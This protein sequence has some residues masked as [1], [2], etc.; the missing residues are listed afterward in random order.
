[1]NIIDDTSGLTVY[2]IANK[3]QVYP[4]NVTSL[5]LIESINGQ[6]S[7]DEILVELNCGNLDIVAKNVISISKTF[8]VQSE[9][10]VQIIADQNNQMAQVREFF[11]NKVNELSISDISSIKV[12][13][14]ALS[15]VT[16]TH[17]Q[18]STN[19]AVKIFFKE[20][21]SGSIF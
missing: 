11:V 17:Q 13:S 5:A 7:S 19:T 4:N 20:N 21:I 10:S 6:Y 8:N 2:Y 14:S 1:M 9:S 16:Q 12:I 15:M 18:I 3:V